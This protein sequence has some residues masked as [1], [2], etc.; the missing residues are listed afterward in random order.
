MEDQKLIAKEIAYPAGRLVAKG[1][2]TLKNQDSQALPLGFRS[3]ADID[4]VYTS[5]DASL[6]V[7]AIGREGPVLA[8]KKYPLKDLQFPMVFELVSSDLL[9]PNTE[10]SWAESANSKDSVALTAIISSSGALAQPQGF[11]RIGLGVSDPVTFAGAKIRSTA[12]INVFDKLNLKLYTPKEIDL[13]SA[14]D[15]ELAKRA[16]TIVS[17]PS[18]PD[19]ASKKSSTT[20]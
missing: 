1:S 8:A 11:E 10:E 15:D 4:A 3:A 17:A 18:A 14:V 19:S 5:N 9:P 6:F 20:K 7:L 2:I 12:R 16:A 13:L